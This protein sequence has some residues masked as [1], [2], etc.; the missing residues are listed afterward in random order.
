[1]TIK[2][3]V[4]EFVQENLD[5]VTSRFPCRAVMVKNV[6]QYNELLLELQ[7]VPGTKLVEGEELFRSADVLPQYDNLCTPQYRDSW[8]IL[9]GVSE[10]LRLFSKSEAES[11]RFARLWTYQ[12][13]ASSTGRVLIPLWGCDAQWHD[14]SLHLCSDE[15]QRPFYYDCYQDEDQEQQ[16]SVTVMSNSFDRYYSH[17]SSSYDRSFPNMLE[18][19]EYWMNPE[20]KVRTIL[21]LTGRYR[22]VNAVSGNVS[23]SVVSD[24]RSYVQSKMPG[25]KA[26]SERHCSEAVLSELFQYAMNGTDLDTAIL[27]VLNMVKFTGTDIAGKWKTMSP[28]Q[29]EM[30]FLWGDTHDMDGYFGGC[31]RKSSTPSELEDHILHDIFAAG[32]THP[33]RVNEFCM[34]V[35]GMGIQKDQKFFDQLDQIPV[36]ED[37]LAYLSGEERSE[38]I[39]LLHLIGK[40]LREDRRQ[41]QSCALLKEIYPALAAYLNDTVYDDELGAYYSRYKAHKLENTLPESENSYFNGIEYDRYD[42][43]YSA[44]SEALTDST[45]VLWVDAM[46]AEWLPLLKWIMDGKNC[47]AVSS[48]L[49]TQATMPTE[50]CFNEQWHQMDVP[51]RKLDKL[52][53]LAH[54][55]VIDDPDYY[56]CVVDQLQFLEEVAEEAEDLLKKYQRV[57]I[58]GD[59]GTSR[60]AARFFHRREGMPAPAGAEVCS[61]GRY[62]RLKDNTDYYDPNLIEMRATDGF[63]YAVYRNY[64]H[65]K[66]PGFAAGAD[67]DNAI[68]GEVHGGATPEEVLVPVLVFDGKTQLPLTAQ[69]DSD[70]VKVRM[71]K[72]KATLKFSKPVKTLQVKIADNNGVCESSAD[73]KIWTA[74]FKG[75]PAKKYDVVVV[76]DGMIVDLPP[77]NIISALGEEDM[78]GLP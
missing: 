16:L 15:R 27:C 1:M 41:V 20:N 42:Y 69:W 78:G 2:E 44:I 13:P 50:T 24:M 21:L 7:H 5:H 37:R 77:L 56:A 63:S 8:L 14:T 47:G 35:R 33:E 57:I 22:K 66:Q 49:V 45:I 17:L 30:V 9:T 32:S 18:W 11:G 46:G 67:D 64:D 36:Y 19:H 60:L 51:Y 10:Y 53:K 39:Y 54:K 38:R 76:A 31:L 71:R 65:F 4:N 12:A 55:G 52:D 75:L 34:L 68:Y 70:K 25:G 28:A 48:C 59:H 26:L 61:H 29:K 23:I 3:V 74:E 72:A 43:R 62:C 6:R 58:T 73:G 40:W